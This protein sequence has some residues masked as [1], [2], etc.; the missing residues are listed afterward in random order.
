MDPDLGL[1]YD[2]RDSEILVNTVETMTDHFPNDDG[3]SGTGIE[4]Y[5]YDESDDAHQQQNANLNDLFNVLAQHGWQRRKGQVTDYDYYADDDEEEEKFEAL[6]MLKRK[7]G[8]EA[9]SFTE[10]SPTVAIPD[11]DK[12]RMRQNITPR[13]EEEPVFEPARAISG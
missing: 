6:E 2:D 5:Y 10:E 4:D 9:G 13:R 11:E 12:P 3:S 7:F 8:G 1:D